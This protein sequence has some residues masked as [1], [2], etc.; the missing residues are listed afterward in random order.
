M[1]G[2][3]NISPDYDNY[4]E[5]TYIT[6]YVHPNANKDFSSVDSNVS[7]AVNKIEYTDGI[8]GEITFYMPNTDVNMTVYFADQTKEL[9]MSTDGTGTGT[10][11]PN[12]GSNIYPVNTVVNIQAI[13]SLNSAF[14]YWT[15][16]GTPDGF[17][18]P[19]NQASSQI[20][21]SS[22]RS[23]TA[24]FLQGKRVYA[25]VNENGNWSVTYLKLN[26]STETLS[27]SGQLP[28]ANIYVACGASVI[29]GGFLS[30]EVC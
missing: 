27:G 21:L 26:G 3:Y 10:T 25:T 5:D 20:R 9:S 11:T 8:H 6:I 12:A 28:G 15:F 19:T 4:F 23:A 7:V 2:V 13:P 18:G 1:D 22:D 17:D 30:N 24:T 14:Q 16:G 29:S